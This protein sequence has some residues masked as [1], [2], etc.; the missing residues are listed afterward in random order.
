MLTIMT[1]N[2]AFTGILSQL[3]WL[4]WIDSTNSKYNSPKIYLDRTEPS[5]RRRKTGP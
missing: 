2:I 5:R 3:D 4:D 1:N